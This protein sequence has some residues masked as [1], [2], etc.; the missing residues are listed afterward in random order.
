[1]P[2]SPL[3]TAAD[4]ADRLGDAD[5]RI[6]DA[7]WRL[8]GRDC[9]P[10]HEAARLPGAVFFDLELSSDT[11]AD[12]PH[13]LPPPAAFAARMGA[14]GLSEADHIVVYDSVGLWSAPRVWWMLKAMGA[15]RVQ[16]L[17]GGLPAWRAAGL[18]VE[19]GPAAPPRP[20]VFHARP[21]R[22]ALATMDDVREALAAGEPVLDARP[23]ARF[24][25]EAAEPRAGLRSGHMPGARNLPF[26]DLLTPDGRLKPAQDLR[27]AFAASGIEPERP[28][29]TTCGSGVTAAILGLGLAALGRPFRL[30]DGS[31]AEW[32]APDGGPV[33][34]GP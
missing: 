13:M 33:A 31:W 29:T 30:Y 11:F 9:R 1:M 17:D 2:D 25:G 34:T 27:A 22:A 20:A 3:I 4:L 12:L 10:D 24:R 21:D 16:V 18:P 14:L 23:A 7:S 28:V 6:V 5:L 26:P 32:G 15:G 19:S 8:D